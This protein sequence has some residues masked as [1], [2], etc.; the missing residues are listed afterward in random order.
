MR[1]IAGWAAL[2][3]ILA[4]LVCNFSA[5]QRRYVIVMVGALALFYYLRRGRRPSALSLDPCLE[6]A[7]RVGWNRVR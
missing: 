3:S 7:R 6:L 2:V 1:R 5:G 4:F